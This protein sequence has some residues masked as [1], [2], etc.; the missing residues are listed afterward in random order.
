[1]K[2]ILSGI[3]LTV[4]SI[5][6]IL[7]ICLMSI[8]LHGVNPVLWGIIGFVIGV[9]GIGAWITYHIMKFAKRA[10]SVNETPEK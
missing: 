6:A 1:M 8:W 7:V 3:G 2:K 10:K 4:F 5:A 9:A